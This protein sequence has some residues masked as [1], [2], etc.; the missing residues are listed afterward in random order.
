MT[1]AFWQGELFSLFPRYR[2]QNAIQSLQSLLGVG[3]GLHGEEA[4]QGPRH[5]LLP[6]FYSN[7]YILLCATHL[8]LNQMIYPFFYHQKS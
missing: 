6:G 5:N 7:Y 3:E 4:K 8:L 2:I 1:Q